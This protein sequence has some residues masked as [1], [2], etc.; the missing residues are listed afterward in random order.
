M[1]FMLCLFICLAFA[2][3]CL[4]TGQPRLPPGPRQLPL[5][6]NL[7]QISRR[8]PWGTIKQWHKTYGPVVSAR[9]G[10]RTFI[11]LGTHKAAKDLLHNRSRNYATRPQSIV[12]GE[13][14]TKGYLTAFLPYGNTFKTHRSLYKSLFNARQ[15]QKY[16]PFH[17]FESK[18]LLFE[19]L[20]TDD[21]FK[22]FDS[23]SY[24]LFFRLVYGKDAA[25]L[26][27][28]REVKLL[29]EI[30]DGLMDGFTR[31]ING[32][33]ESFPILHR[34]PPWLARW[35]DEGS[36]YFERGLEF[37]ERNLA[38]SLGSDS[39]NLAKE[40]FLHG[41]AQGLSDREL[42]YFL[43]HIHTVSSHTTDKVLQVFVMACVLYPAAVSTAQQELDQVTGSNRLPDFRDRS[44]LPYVNAFIH[45]VLRWRPVTPGGGP[46]AA[47]EQ[48]SYM[49]YDIPKGTIVVATNWALDLNEDTH[50]DPFVF[51]PERWIQN[52]ELPLAAFGFGARAC[53]GQ[54]FALDA[55][56]II[57][58]RI[59]WAYNIS[60]TFTNGRKDYVD[61]WSFTHGLTSGPTPFG[62]SLKART[63]KHQ[64]VVENE[65][66]YTADLG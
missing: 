30:S 46:H 36:E 33:I 61:P 15:S 7:H 29:K 2:W 25:R 55:L 34:L 56:F 66:K 5:I 52:R 49:G 6:G 58:S 62:A 18:R 43:A 42:A 9:F 40:T 57:I 14:M 53:K 20:S 32:I 59:L 8:R 64:L 44:N 45:E 31:E 4:T 63:P 23:Y 1:I 16:Q 41:K 48:D 17:S 28:G 13:S 35:K 50:E 11:L 10:Q 51:R 27:N 26:D 37:C 60:A 39:W 22:C 65:W 24:Q 47:I 19:L 21:F 12:F 38:E 3:W 54:V